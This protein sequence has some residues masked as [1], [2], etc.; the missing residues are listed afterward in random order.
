MNKFFI[1]AL[2]VAS[3][4]ALS[5][6]TADAKRLGGGSSSG[7]QRNMPAKSAPDAALARP[8]AP[9]AATPA[10]PAAPAAAPKRNWMGPLA[11]L[12]A[13]LGIAALMS[14][15]GMG[16]AFGNFLT[17]ALLAL[18]AVFAIRFLMKRFG[19]GMGG[20]KPALAGMGASGG[21]GAFNNAPDNAPK[22][23]MFRTAD[24]SSSV[25]PFQNPTPASLNTDTPANV[26]TRNHVPADFDS[27]GFERIAKMIFIRMQT[28]ND[29][30][31]LNDLRNFTT[32]EMFASIR[33][34][35]QE[36]GTA[37]QETDVVKVDAQVLD[38]ATEADR[39]I[40]SVRFHGM[41]REEKDAVAAP[42]DEV[43]HLVKPQDD[44]RSW[45]IAGIEQ[46]H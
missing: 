10:T 34:E 35:L 44:S 23:N 2:L 42:F 17:M 45:A 21:M 28:A 37:K 24:P 31:D 46:N 3:A 16:A 33:L 27:P 26:V 36:R 1:T 5:P 41:I 29:A 39:Q 12:A 8:A 20:N 9:A 14:H 25:T 6:L 43:W 4:T 18:V 38:V 19:G 32:P 30:A 13:G 15:L 11:G 40:V 22:N 7:M